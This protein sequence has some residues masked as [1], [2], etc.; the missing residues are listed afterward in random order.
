[1]GVP[2]SFLDKYNLIN[3]KLLG[4]V[5]IYQDPSKQKM[6]GLPD[7]KTATDICDKRRSRRFALPDGD[8]WRRIYDRIVIRKK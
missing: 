3:L 7:I 1:M 2:I 8:T 5:V 6:V 4:Q